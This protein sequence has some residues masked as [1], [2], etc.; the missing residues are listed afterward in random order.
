MG[1]VCRTATSPLFGYRLNI[2][3]AAPTSNFTFT[4]TVHVGDPKHALLELHIARSQI[5]F[6]ESTPFTEMAL[7]SMCQSMRCLPASVVSTCLR[8]T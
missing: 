3:A 7:L 6:G 8:K 5:P 4:N 2:G 1:P